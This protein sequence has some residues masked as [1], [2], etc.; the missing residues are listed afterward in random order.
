V[1][2]ALRPL[3]FLGTISYGLYLWHWPVFVIFD[4]G[5]LHLEGPALLEEPH[6]TTVL[7][8][9]DTLRVDDHDALLITVG[10]DGA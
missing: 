7:L 10:G 4:S 6:T 5:R 1:R 9:G 3:T 2:K 8:P